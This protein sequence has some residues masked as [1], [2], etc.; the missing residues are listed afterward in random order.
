MNQPPLTG[1]YTILALLLS[2]HLENKIICQIRNTILKE[3]IIWVNLLKEA[4]LQRCG[5]LLYVRLKQHHLFNELPP[6]VQTL[7][8]HAYNLNVERNTLF[9]NIL[10]ELLAELSKENIDSLLLKGAA[11]FCDDLYNDPGARVM[12]D[13]DLLVPLNKIDKCQRI[14]DTLGYYKIDNPDRELDGIATDERH[15]HL[16]PHY[17][18]GTSLPV[19]IH[20]KI[21]YAQAGR[22]LSTAQTWDRKISTTLGGYET[23]ILNPQDRLILNTVHALLP[24]REFIRGRIELLQLAEFALM[25]TEFATEIDW[26]SWLSL[27]KQHQLTSEFLTYLTLAHRLMNIPWPSAVPHSKI[28]QLHSKRILNA[29]T[30]QHSTSSRKWHTSKLIRDGYYYANLP[31]WIWTNVCYAPGL[32][33]IPD[34]V[35]LLLKKLLSVHNWSKI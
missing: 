33:N 18:P 9:K 10:I 35:Q 14:L 13:I 23:S 4:S 2:P 32:N 11:T 30:F 15:H 12:G 19:E 31:V 29:E 8:Q 34:R 17:H 1:N 26:D 16:L 21:A 7:L 27:A 24:H 3:Q 6:A 20:F 22:V 5:P 28:A 25:A